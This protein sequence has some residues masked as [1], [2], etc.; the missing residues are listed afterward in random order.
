M[1]DWTQHVDKTSGRVYYHNVVTKQTTW[2]APVSL[3]ANLRQPS[4]QRPSPRGQSSPPIQQQNRA[5]VQ[6]QAQHS[7]IMLGQGY[8]N[9]IHHQHQ[10]QHQRKHSA[11]HNMALYDKSKQTP[12]QPQQHVSQQQQH[13]FPQVQHHQHQ[14]KQGNISVQFQKVRNQQQHLSQHQQKIKS[15]HKMQYS[16]PQLQSNAKRDTAIPRGPHK[17]FI[18]GNYESFK[19]GDVTQVPHFID[20]EKNT[21]TKI[22]V[23]GLSQM[24]KNHT[25]KTYFQKYGTIDDAIVLKDKHTKRSRG[26]GFVV[27]KS[28]T[29]LRGVF[30]DAPHTLCG[31][32][33]EVKMA[34]EKFRHEVS[35]SPIATGNGV[36]PIRKT[37]TSP[38]SPSSKPSPMQLSPK[39]A[40]KSNHKAGTRKTSEGNSVSA[41]NMQ[42]S[43]SVQNQKKRGSVARDK[44]SPRLIKDVKKRK[45]NS[46]SHVHTVRNGDALASH[47]KDSVEQH[48][49]AFSYTSHNRT[50][51]EVEARY[52]NP[53]PNNLISVDCN[54]IFTMPVDLPSQKYS[55]SLGTEEADDLPLHRSSKFRVIEDVAFQDA[56][57]EKDDTNTASSGGKENREIYFANVILF[58]GDPMHGTRDEFCSYMPTRASLRTR[59]SLL[60]SSKSSSKS[61]EKYF[62]LPGGQWSESLDGG[63]PSTDD[64]D[65]IATAIRWTRTLSGIDLSRCTRWIKF[66]QFNY[67]QTK[68]AMKT[69]SNELPRQITSVV[70]LPDIWNTVPSQEEYDG[71][72]N[73]LIEKLSRHERV[74]EASRQLRQ[75]TLLKS[76]VLKKKASAN[77][78]D[79]NAELEEV[80]TLK[81]TSLRNRLAE[82]NIASKGLKKAELQKLLRA[83]LQRDRKMKSQSDSNQI[84]NVQVDSSLIPSIPEERCLL[85]FCPSLAAT[86]N[87][88]ES[89]ILGPE[90]LSSLLQMPIASDGTNDA[91]IS[92]TGVNFE[93]SIV[94][95]MF[96]EML[97]RRFAAKLFTKLSQKAHPQA[98]KDAADFYEC[99]ASFRYFDDTPD[100]AIDSSTLI[101]AFQNLGEGISKFRLNELLGRPPATTT[102]PGKPSD[103]KEDTDVMSARI[104]YST[105]LGEQK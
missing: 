55:L 39:S 96:D 61:K 69:P 11:Q 57:S 26:F 105:L 33:V 24:V 64:R 82:R 88:G 56:Y 19:Q 40:L 49:S 98:S 10:L 65:L 58:S 48:V 101:K 73:I 3:Y 74:E 83:E 84:Q 28:S 60:V 4:L 37:S 79:T 14:H 89:L 25:L 53:V 32:V 104:S 85:V 100:M 80:K 41:S 54:W 22:F 81:V 86:K 77:Y 43:T 67:E 93:L 103:K 15:Q 59:L 17:R 31:K 87:R 97:Q 52:G 23:G 6:P 7:G 44:G 63:D 47:S 95:K 20:R 12:V 72:R 51:H 75:Q 78:I 8:K 35:P 13:Q 102:S 46:E 94:A 71:Y 27:Y 2:N 34:N 50:A 9:L 90:R 91:S 99:V 16:V 29:S 42:N 21:N 30:R 36:K 38:V 1:S 18:Q 92:L 76:P 68:S 70:F 45:L 62:S 5:H 66:A